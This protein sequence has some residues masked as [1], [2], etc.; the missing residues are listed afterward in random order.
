MRLLD[1]YLAK[2]ILLAL[3]MVVLLLF[4]LD[5]FFGFIQ[6][7]KWVGRGSYTLGLAAA[8]LLMI[9][10][11][12]VYQLLPWAACLGTLLGLGSLSENSEL[13]VMRASGVSINRIAVGALKGIAVFV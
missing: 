11:M 2:Q 1:I 3:L 4:G 12:K 10:P 7:M 6:E 9:S 5:L 13:T 8:Y